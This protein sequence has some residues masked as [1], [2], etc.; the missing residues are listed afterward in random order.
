MTWI[1][2]PQAK[3]LYNQGLISDQEYMDII[4]AID[5]EE[6]DWKLDEPQIAQREDT[7]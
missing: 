2:R 6:A 7:Y 5:E 4:T 1:T 3:K